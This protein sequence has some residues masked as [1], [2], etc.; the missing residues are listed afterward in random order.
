MSTSLLPIIWDHSCC[1]VDRLTDGTK[2]KPNQEEA[3]LLWKREKDKLLKQ[4]KLEQK[5]QKKTTKSDKE[6]KDGTEMV[7]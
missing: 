4:K 2:G 7:G 3:F 6:K 1:F 5:I